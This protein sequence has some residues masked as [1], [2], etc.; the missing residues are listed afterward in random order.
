MFGGLMEGGEGLLLGEISGG[1]LDEDVGGEV[2]SLS[3]YLRPEQA[4]SRF[5][6]VWKIYIFRHIHQ[7]TRRCSLGV[8]FV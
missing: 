4:Q 7:G 1:S 5:I 8:S 6:S 3:M 2:G